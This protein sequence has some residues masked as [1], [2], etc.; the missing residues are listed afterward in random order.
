MGIKMAAP[1]FQ[2]E[3]FFRENGAHDVHIGLAVV[4]N[5]NLDRV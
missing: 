2:K 4:F 3:H 5:V 1:L